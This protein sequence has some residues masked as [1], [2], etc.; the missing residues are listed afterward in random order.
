MQKVILKF[1]ERFAGTDEDGTIVEKVLKFHENY[2]NQHQQ[3][4]I[5]LSEEKAV[6]FYYV[7][8]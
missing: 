3:Y 5:Y 6:K 8:A 7:I 2:N 1:D 4:K